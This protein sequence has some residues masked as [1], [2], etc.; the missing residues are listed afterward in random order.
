MT[1]SQSNRQI[2]ICFINLKKIKIMKN[3]LIFLF[4]TSC[5]SLIHAQV[6]IGGAATNPHTSSILE[7]DGGSTRGLLLPRMTTANM[8]AIASPA[9]GLMIY[10]TTEKTTYFRTNNEWIKSGSGSGF[11]LPYAGDAN[12]GIAAFSVTNSG[13]SGTGIYGKANAGF[14]GGAGVHGDANVA[15]SY[16]IKGTGSQATGGY[17]NSTNKFSLVTDKGSVGFGT[18]SPTNAFI[19]VNGTNSNLTTMLLYDEN[20]TIQF[21][22]QT[23]NS[24]PINKGFIQLA[25]HDLKIGT[26]FE[27][28]LGQFVIRT[29]GLD[30][31]F[32]WSNG[33]TRIPG[34]AGILSRLG[35]GTDSATAKIEINA[36]NTSDPAMIINDESPTIFL[37]N[38]GVDK[39]F[40][41]V[42]GNDLKIGN[43]FSNTAGKVIVRT[44]GLDRVFVDNN[45]NMS[46][47]SSQVADGYKLSVD[48]KVIA[49][50]LRIQNS[51]S[52]PDYVFNS[53]YKLLS[54][55]ETKLFIAQNN[56]LPGIPSACEIEKEGIPVGKMQTLMMEKIEEL[57]LHLIKSQEQ[58]IQLQNQVKKLSS[59]N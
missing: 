36:L 33:Y 26:N 40:V 23:G 5:F 51:T 28:Q 42:A 56:R 52:W 27:N 14:G 49:E 47:G 45:G 10:N 25:N 55:E 43:P 34:N 6:K 13:L 12:I 2:Y 39:G 29:G 8:N 3:K 37:R 11:S 57:T 35:V 53:D 41:Q 32:V 18:L 31:V 7:L 50:E 24:G 54:L 1:N 59:D 21:S 17:F 30:R 38:E 46:I 9:E 22:N 58:I 4:F 20:P 44:G 16:G 19:E 48:G 15:G